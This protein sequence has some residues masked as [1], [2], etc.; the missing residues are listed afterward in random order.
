VSEAVQPVLS[1]PAQPLAEPMLPGEEEEREEAAKA[2]RS[3]DTLLDDALSPEARNQ[4]LARR[5][6]AALGPDQLPLTASRE[7]VT[8]AMTVLLPAIRGC[9]MGQ[10]GL[11]TAAMVVRNDGKV[12]GVEITGA[13][14]EGT[15]S[16]RCMEG[17]I[18]RARMAPFR[19]STMRIRFPLA[20]Q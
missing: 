16:G 20:I 15:A 7:E 10:A 9:A 4:E 12:A 6:A 2:A 19:Q 3:M 18:R 17:V 1:A 14:F 8:R 5:Q 11:A 13:P